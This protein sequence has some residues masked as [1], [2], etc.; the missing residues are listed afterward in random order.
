MNMKARLL[1]YLPRHA[2]VCPTPDRFGLLLMANLHRVVVPDLVGALVESD[3]EGVQAGDFALSEDTDVALF[4]LRHLR[5]TAEA[6][7]FGLVGGPLRARWHPQV[8]QSDR[9]REAS[10]LYR[11]DS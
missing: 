2:R 5:D 4:K 8:L 9:Q 3:L 1:S 11:T 7:A 6:E 10:A